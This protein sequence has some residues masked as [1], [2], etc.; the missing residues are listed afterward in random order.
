MSFTKVTYRKFLNDTQGA[1]ARV[2]QIQALFLPFVVTWFDFVVE[3]PVAAVVV[4]ISCL[5]CCVSVVAALGSSWCRRW[6][7]GLLRPLHFRD[8]VTLFLRGDGQLAAEVVGG[9]LD[10]QPLEV[11]NV[12]AE[13]EDKYGANLEISFLDQNFDKV[14][15]IPNFY[16]KGC[17]HPDG[18]F[19]FWAHV[20]SLKCKSH[21]LSITIWYS[22]YNSWYL[23]GLT[24][25]LMLL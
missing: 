19:I 9:L 24:K 20:T 22:V 11:R 23:S 8:E 16:K 1:E 4:H 6:A 14:H 17:H 21:V 25:W 5:G 15:I 12:E 18:Y 13:D 10:G 2:P 3:A 7:P